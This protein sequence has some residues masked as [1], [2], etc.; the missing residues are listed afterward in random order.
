MKKIL[1]AF[2]V[3]LIAGIVCVLEDAH[4]ST[5]ESPPCAACKGVYPDSASLPLT[6]VAALARNPPQLESAPFRM[7]AHLRND[8]GRLV[9]RQ[10]G[11]IGTTAPELEAGIN[12]EFAACE[13]AMKTL[14]VQT[15]Y[16]SWYEG[17]ADVVIIARLA[18][19]ESEPTVEIL[20]LEKVAPAS[21][22]KGFAQKIR[23]ALRRLF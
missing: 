1:I 4:V 13:G 22:L 11:A 23:Y 7:E 3:L 2:G 21:A 14:V 18:D 20:C 5:L 16:T 8:S 17:A 19:A 12:V 15:G 9:L 10:A 6:S